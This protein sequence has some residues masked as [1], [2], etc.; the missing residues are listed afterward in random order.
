MGIACFPEAGEHAA[1]LV[2]AA[3]KALAEARA[4]GGD[5]WELAGAK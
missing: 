5:G 2:G 1:S 4:N 3:D